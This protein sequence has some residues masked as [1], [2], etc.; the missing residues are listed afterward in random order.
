MLKINLRD[1]PAEERWI[2]HSRLTAPWVRE[3]RA[4][5]RKNHRTEQVRPCI[6]DLNEVTFIDKSGQRLL[7]VLVSEGADV[8]RAAFTSST[9]L[10]N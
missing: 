9:Y 4:S 7:R 1:T 8:S 6:I 2:L 10:S 3:L 5:W